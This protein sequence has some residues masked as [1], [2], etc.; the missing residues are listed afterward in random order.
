MYLAQEVAL[1]GGCD[2]VGVGV[3]SWVWALKPFAEVPGS[4]YSASSLQMKL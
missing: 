1:L 2:I 3:A 4:E